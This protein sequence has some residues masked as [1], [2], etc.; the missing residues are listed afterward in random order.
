M[1]KAKRVTITE[2]NQ[3]EVDRLLSDTVYSRFAPSKCYKCGVKKGFKRRIF[4]ISGIQKDKYADD[5]TQNLLRYHFFHQNKIECIFFRT[6]A[7][8]FY[9]DSATCQACKSMNVVFDIV[10][11]DKLMAEYAKAVGENVEL[12]RARIESMVKKL[13]S[14]E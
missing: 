14:G 11:D 2:L 12:A 7:G 8:K 10:L 9:V 5:D 4:H 13:E 3:M 6:N 1:A